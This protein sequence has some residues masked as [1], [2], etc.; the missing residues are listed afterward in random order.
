VGEPVPCPNCGSL[1]RLPAGATTVRCPSCKAVLEV[2]TDDGPPAPPPATPVA[3]P[4][5]FGRPVTLPSSPVKPTPAKGRTVAGDPY[6]PATPEQADEDARERDIRRQLREL[7]VAEERKAER[8]EVLA[9]ECAKAR[10]GLKLIAVGALLSVFSV[11]LALFFV[12]AAVVGV[13]VILLVAVGGGLFGV[14][15]LLTLAG[16]G[17]CLAGP[18]E[19]RGT[20]L[21]GVGFTLAHLAF[22][23]I[24]AG[25]GVAPAVGLQM[26]QE[27]DRGESF[28]FATLALANSVCNLTVITDLPYY[29]LHPADVSVRAVVL[30]LIAA[31]FEFAKLSA[32][33]LLA[34]QYATAAKDPDLA[35][36]GMRFVYRIFGLLLLGPLVKLVASICLENGIVWIPLLLGTVGYMLWWCF[37]W[38]AQY[39]VLNDIHEIVTAVRLADTRQRY[40]SW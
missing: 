24:A 16:L 29:W 31:G 14:H 38:L 2:D 23:A 7:D 15:G 12:I 27:P 3:I 19:M 30:L 17:F 35:H 32:I 39:Q 37:A 21:A 25:V 13:P 28:L 11:L 34:N 5:P 8:Y 22:A 33:G 6:A 4:L 1:L 40:D 9:A 26:L 18:R 36:A 10:T 20:A